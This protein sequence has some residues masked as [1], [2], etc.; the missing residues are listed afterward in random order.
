MQAR[1]ASSA[2]TARAGTPGALTLLHTTSP[3][4]RRLRADEK[5]QPADPSYVLALKAALADAG[6]ADTKLIVMDGGFDAAEM[7][8]ATPSSPTYNASF[9]AAV[10]GAGLHYP[11][12]APHPE[13]REAGWTFWAS[14]DYSRTETSWQDGASYWA[15]VLNNNYILV[16]PLRSI[17]IEPG[18]ASFFSPLHLHTHLS[19]LRHSQT[20]AHSRT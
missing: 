14:E 8:F 19:Q 1:A 5:P 10:A 3:H 11:C 15:Q 9:A 2:V 17:N 16:R 6:A 12:N 7:A 4:F 18:A 13:V 20:F